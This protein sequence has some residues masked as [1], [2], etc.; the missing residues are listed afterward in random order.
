MEEEIEDPY[1]DFKR[2]LKKRK[3]ELTRP[4]ATYKS[5][6]LALL[7]KNWFKEF[8]VWM[9]T[10]NAPSPGPISNH[11]LYTDGK[12]DSE[13]KYGHDFAVVTPKVYDEIFP[14]FKGGPKI[15]RPY[16]LEPGTDKPTFIL[17]PIV[18]TITYQ[19]KVY[20]KQTDPHWK[21]GPI[22]GTLCQLLKISRRKSRFRSF[23]DNEIIEDSL[24]VQT[25]SE[26]F[27]NSF[28]LEVDAKEQPVSRFQFSEPTEA[29]GLINT[30]INDYINSCIQCLIRVPPLIDFVLAEGFEEQLAL[31]NKK[32][33]GGEIARAFR[34]L[35]QELLTA[36]NT[37]RDPIPLYKAVTSKYNDIIDFDR[38]DAVEMLFALLDGLFE[39]TN[40]SKTNQNTSPI[41]D[42]FF[43]IQRSHVECSICGYND[44][45]REHFLFMTVPIPTT[46]DKK[47]RI[48][49]QDC[50]AHF[51]MPQQPDDHTK[52]NCKKCKKAVPV[53]KTSAIDMVA[54]VLI[55]QLQRFNGIA[56]FSTSN[57]Q[58]VEYPDEIDVASFSSSSQGLYKLIAV[59][60][61]QGYL[62]DGHYT[63]AALD[64]KDDQWLYFDDKNVL[65]V[66]P[67][68]SHNDDA[69]V[70]FYQK[71]LD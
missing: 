63:C 19:D 27:S 42:M 55:I 41:A 59:I 6:Y 31:E 20:R 43:G 54:D 36:G 38:R 44:E 69:Y 33:S 51:S 34:Y 28:I 62:E 3:E 21:I 46:G 67:S 35:S 2:D 17:D 13:K 65:A 9:N 1:L 22:R 4:E 68:G 23:N 66:D 5:I 47:Q 49:L 14:I 56:S 57:E 25:V 39:D 18:L 29:H 40:K 70:L 8:V 30:A 24:D 58:P 26:H 10:K 16:V 32:G 64:Q 60:F 37:Q 12:L 71:S 50:I 53:F 45:V 52:Y 48:L 61:H 11:L 15:V 7:E